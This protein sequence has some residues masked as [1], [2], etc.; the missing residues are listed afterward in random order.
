MLGA[1]RICGYN[2]HVLKTLKEV[3]QCYGQL[4]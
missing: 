1:G 2:F 3:F 4:Q